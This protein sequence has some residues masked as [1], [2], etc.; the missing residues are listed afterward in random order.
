MRA[1][2]LV[3]TATACAALRAAA[4]RRLRPTRRLVSMRGLDAFAAAAD[5]SWTRALNA[6]PESKQHEP[7]KSSRRV[8]SGHYVPVVPT[9]LQSPELK[10]HSRELCEELGL[11]EAD[12]KDERFARFFSGDVDA[13]TLGTTWATPYALSIMGEPQTRNCPFGTGEGY[14]DGRAVSLGEVVVDDKRWELQLKG[15]GRT[16]FCRGADGRAVLRSSLREFL[17]SEAMHFLRVPT[18]RA[19]S[20]VVSRTETTKRPWYSGARDDAVPAPSISEDDPRLAKFPPQVRKQLIRQLMRQGGDDP[21]VMIEESCA[22]TCRVAPS[23]SRVGHVDLF[24]RRARQDAMRMGEYEKI[25]QHVIAREYPELLG[26]DATRLPQVKDLKP[27]ALKFAE[28][29]RTKLASLAANWLRVG[30]CQGNFNADNCLVGGRTMDYG[31]FG[32]LDQYDPSFAKWVGSGDHFAFA[33]QPGAALANWGT[34]VRSLAPLF[35]DPAPLQALLDDAHGYFQAAV[36][37]CYRRKLGFPDGVDASAEPKSLWRRLEP[38]LRGMDYTIFFRELATC[39][40]GGDASV[41]EK[42]CYEPLSEEK[43]SFLNEWLNDWRAAVGDTAG[44]ADRMRLENPKHILR[45]WMLVEAYDAAGAGDWSVAEELHELIREPYADRAEL[46]KKYY[47][48]APDAALRRP[49]T[50]WMT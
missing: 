49:G 31:P 29:S 10:L 30:F 45:E 9:A 33:N 39:V 42:A 13:L 27:V 28:A 44:V 5:A 38:E 2:Q 40:E 4:V 23:F 25:V 32:F 48:R 21:D 14:G 50:A 43:R 11:A 46:D 22:I 34:L 47:R 37:D 24:A 16:P 8:K 36:D 6:D 18:T 17:A 19:L 26:E 7:N 20:L 3:Y 15:G 1:P 35:D 41:L 12:V